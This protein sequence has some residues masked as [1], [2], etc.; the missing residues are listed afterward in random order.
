VLGGVVR[1]HVGLNKSCGT[2]RHS[3]LLSFDICGLLLH[4]AFVVHCQA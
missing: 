4:A 2:T 1:F 3:G